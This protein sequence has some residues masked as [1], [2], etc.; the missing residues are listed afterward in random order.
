MKKIATEIKNF[1]NKGYHSVPEKWRQIF[2]K[3]FWEKSLVLRQ[4]F[5]KA[6]LLEHK[7]AHHLKYLKF[8]LEEGPVLIFLHGFADEKHNFFLAGKFLAKKFKIIVPDI[9]GF[10]ESSKHESEIYMVENYAK[11]I[12]DLVL[13]LGLTEFHLMGNSLGGAI[14]IKYTLDY[15]QKVKSLVLIDSAGVHPEKCRSLYCE[16]L[17]GQNLF[18]LKHSSEFHNFLNRVFNKKPFIPTPIFNFLSR[19]FFDNRDWFAKITDDLVYGKEGP[20][21]EGLSWDERISLALNPH[22]KKIKAPT[23]IVWGECDTFFP[24][25]VGHIIKREIENSQLKIYPQ[26]GHSPQAE[27][28]WTFVRDLLLFYQLVK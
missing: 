1:L 16:F 12:D 26:V 19:E 4:K 24:V 14:A 9:P 2:E 17:E 13:S 10:G 15:P 11:W 20:T 27:I 25:E 5:L 6:E 18:V 7:G 8:G 3:N 28:P 22:L 21:T 23:Y